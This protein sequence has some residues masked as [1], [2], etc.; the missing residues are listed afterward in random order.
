[1]A[2]SYTETLLRVMLHMTNVK[3][4]I[5][6]MEV[7]F[8]D[9]LALPPGIESQDARFNDFLPLAPEVEKTN[10]GKLDL[11]TLWPWLKKSTKAV[12]GSI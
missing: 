11:I 5:A 9:F 6:S 1:M 3:I 7:R 8:D 12:P 4:Y 10:P 2:K